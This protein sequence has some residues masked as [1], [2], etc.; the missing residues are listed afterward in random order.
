MVKKLLQPQEIEVF[1]VIPALRRELAVCMKGSGKSQK[2]IAGLLGVTEAAV[3]HYFSSK[4]AS[5]LK[6]GS[7]LKKEIF[8][9][10][11][12]ISDELSLMREMQRLLQLARVERVVC[13][14]CS[15]DCDVC[16]EG[17]K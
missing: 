11:A 17:L 9:S 10:A 5:Q 15:K 7:N 6:F 3:S 1:Y 4:R 16:F 2:V 14:H 12:R 13:S 8:E